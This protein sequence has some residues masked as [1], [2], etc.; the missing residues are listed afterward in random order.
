MREKPE[1]DDLKD[2]YWL[3]LLKMSASKDSKFFRILTK[4]FQIWEK[5]RI[6]FQNTLK[7]WNTI[8]Q[9]SNFWVTTE[10]PAISVIFW[11]LLSWA[12]ANTYVC[13]YICMYTSSSFHSFLRRCD[14]LLYI[15]MV[16]ILIYLHFNLFLRKHVAIYNKH[17][18]CHLIHKFHLEA[19]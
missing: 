18:N 4:H 9:V 11:S 14:I 12:I 13:M 5:A 17:L 19:Y 10:T 2:A 1:S 15:L 6:Q 16:N 8:I 3:K 7:M